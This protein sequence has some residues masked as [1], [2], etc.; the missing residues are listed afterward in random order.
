MQHRD[1]YVSKIPKHTKQ[2]KKLGK[3]DINGSSIDKL[4]SWL[5]IF[6][7]NLSKGSSSLHT[8][9]DAC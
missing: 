9:T 7:F 3:R 1:T 5:S 4:Q 2:N 8:T 6:I